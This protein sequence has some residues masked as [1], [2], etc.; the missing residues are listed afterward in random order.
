MITKKEKTLLW[1]SSG[2]FIIPEILWSPIIN[3]INDLFQNTNNTII[4]RPNFLTNPNNINLLILVLSIETI[5]LLINIFLITK[6]SIKKSVKIFLF[7][8][9]IILSMIACLATYLAFS[10]RHGI[11]L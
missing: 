8:I 9:L 11:G 1:I 3:I 4:F 6:I 10:L 7:L 5:S 2:L